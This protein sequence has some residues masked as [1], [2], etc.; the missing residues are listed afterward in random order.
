MK[1]GRLSEF[2]DEF[3]AITG[4]TIIVIVMVNDV[5]VRPIHR[6]PVDTVC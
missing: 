5:V 6:V 1:V 4:V 2:G 3:A